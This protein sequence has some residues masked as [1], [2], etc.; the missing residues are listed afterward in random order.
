MSCIFICACVSPLINY[1]L[2]VSCPSSREILATPLI[3]CRC[4]CLCLC[5]CLC[6]CVLTGV[7]TWHPTD[8][9]THRINHLFHRRH[10]NVSQTLQPYPS[11]LIMQQLSRFCSNRFHSNST[12]FFLPPHN[13]SYIFELLICL[14]THY[15]ITMLS[16][17][18]CCFSTILCR[19]GKRLQSFTFKKHPKNLKSPNFRFLKVFFIGFG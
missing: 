7:I 15:L 16:Y 18:D 17:V 11:R 10:S 3:L 9:P 12:D 6:A 4:I 5:V 13:Y 2:L 1:F 8:T 19:A 14:I